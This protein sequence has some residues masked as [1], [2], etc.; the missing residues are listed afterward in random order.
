MLR[1]SIQVG[2]IPLNI[3]TFSYLHLSLSEAQQPFTMRS[4]SS[5][6]HCTLSNLSLY[7]HQLFIVGPTVSNLSLYFHQLFIVGPTVSKLSLYFHQLFIVGP[8]L[9]NLSLYFHQ[10]FI[11]LSA[12]FHC[13][14]SNRSLEC[15][16]PFIELPIISKLSAGHLRLYTP[17]TS[18]VFVTQTCTCTTLAVNSRLY[19]T[20]PFTP[21]NLHSLTIKERLDRYVMI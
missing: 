6:F 20:T 3:Q 21:Q 18:S 12:T 17:I 8:T 19:K 5:T 7:F 13:T 10:L 15:H 9:S 2:F 16:Q 14:L 1:K 11:V 4:G